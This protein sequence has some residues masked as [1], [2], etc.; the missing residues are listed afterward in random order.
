[1]YILTLHATNCPATIIFNVHI[2]V[3]MNILLELMSDTFIQLQKSPHFMPLLET[4]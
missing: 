2:L 3:C 1:V 4:A